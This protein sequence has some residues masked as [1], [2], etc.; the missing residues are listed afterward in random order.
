MEIW[1][2]RFFCNHCCISV[3]CLPQFAQP[4]RVVNSDTVQ[5]AFDEQHS[6]PEVQ[7]WWVLLQSYWRRFQRHLPELLLRV[8][9]NFG[10]L[11]VKATARDFW[12][13]CLQTCGDW[14][15][16][17]QELIARF[18]TCLFGTY[19]CHQRKRFRAA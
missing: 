1:V 17:T 8:G 6:R 5:A 9:Q 18:G 7:R 15:R 3:S 2:R 19:R 13:R 14:G 16:T 4:Y 12:K 11:P 10:A